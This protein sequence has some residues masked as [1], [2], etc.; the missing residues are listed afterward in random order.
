ME[1]VKE[2]QEHLEV[3]KHHEKLLEVLTD[4][5]RRAESEEAWERAHK[6]YREALAKEERAQRAEQTEEKINQD[7]PFTVAGIDISDLPVD[8]IDL[9]KI[10]VE[11]DRRRI[12]AEHNAEIAYMQEKHSNDIAAADDREQQ[13]QRQNEILQD[14][15]KNYESE[16]ERLEAQIAE[17]RRE[18]LQITLERDDARQGK[19]AAVNEL[20]EARKEIKRLN[21]QMLEQQRAHIL[22]ER[23]AQKVIDVTSEQEKARD[24]VA[25]IKTA[26][27]LAM[28]GVAFRGKVSI[29]GQVHEEPL[30]V[31][32][33]RSEG[34]TNPIAD[35]QNGGLLAP[36]EVDP[37]TFDP[38]KY[39]PDATFPGGQFPQEDHNTGP[40][41]AELV[42]A[43]AGQ[44]VEP[45]TREE[46]EA[47]KAELI[48][49]QQRVDKLEEVCDIEEAA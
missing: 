2:S 28:E 32:S 8:Y 34:E 7:V 45:V 37:T 17:L 10:I 49:T 14:R 5:A 15:E 12:Y 3:M 39:V 18:N 22:G 29:G 19:Q 21:D 6:A 16:R 43:S 27:E 25:K 20:E 9:V 40:V 46:F 13:L 24:L 30:Q 36:P 1:N 35:T 42:Q 41:T 26:R 47:L 48:K 38:A 23:Q 4:P 33:F 11:A 31:P 44:D